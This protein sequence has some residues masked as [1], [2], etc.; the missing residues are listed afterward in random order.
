M[1]LVAPAIAG[2]EPGTR[3]GPPIAYVNARLIDPASGL[4]TLGGAVI[5]ALFVQPRGIY[6]RIDGVDLWPEERDARRYA[7]PWPVVAHPPC[8]RFGR[9]AGA[10]W[11][12]R[13]SIFPRVL[14]MRGASLP[15]CGGWRNCPTW[16][17]AARIIWRRG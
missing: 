8:E 3:G 1:S 12:R 14:V 17:S 9:W 4:D 6:S 16:W 5:A 7:G 2:T 10:M 15:I 11:R 13:R